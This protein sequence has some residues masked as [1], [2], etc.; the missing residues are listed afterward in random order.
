MLELFRKAISSKFGAGVAIAIL[1][2]IALSFAAGDVSGGLGFGKSGS[3][4]AVATVGGEQ[5]DASTL[6]QAATSAL[7]NVKQSDPKQTMK[8]FV[9]SG[10]L[11]NVLDG[12]IDRLAIAV[13]GKKHGIV[14]SDKLIDSEIAQMPAFKGADGKFNPAIYKQMMQQRGIS[15]GLLRNDL[16]QGLIARQIMIPASLGASIPDRLAKEYASLLTE[17]RKGEIAVLPSLAFASKDAPTDAEL[18][19]YYSEHRDRFIRP[20]RRVI[21]YAAFGEEI[22]KGDQPQPTDAEIAARYNENKAQYAAREERRLTQ[23]IVPT[24][25]AAKAVVAEIAGGKSLEVAAK[26][27]GLSTSEVGPIDKADLAKQYSQDVADAAFAAS[28][29]TMAALSHGPLGWHVIRVAGI[30]RTPEKTLAQA[31]GE[32]AKALAAEKKRA[33]LSARLEEVENAFDSGSSL[34]EEAKALGVDIK[35]TPPVTADGKVYM[36]PSESVPDT[37]KPVLQTAFSMDSEKPQLAEVEH[38]KTFVIFDVTDIAQSAPAPLKEIKDDVKAAYVLDKAAAA[39]KQAALDMQA[40]IAKGKSMKE[41]LAS[42]KRNL[43]PVQTVAMSR[44]QLAQIQ[45]QGHQVPR[46]IALLFNM[47]KGTTKVQP[48]PNEQAWFVITLSDIVPGKVDDAK[49]LEA[50]HRQLGP[51]VGSELSDALGRA[52]RKQIGVERNAAAIKAVRQKL[53]GDSTP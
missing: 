34:A 43:P 44:P 19:A 38:G 50:A 4:N 47:A 8:T 7:E 22:L 49:L 27:K 5:I 33:A 16:A 36:K 10:G 31:S 23:L 20:E 51:V 9:A 37:L 53:T 15:E 1:I 30:E 52:I 46:P 39:A 45:Q 29:G 18:G 14:A 28:Q 26:S 6:N 17:S 41:A 12:L 32:I 21:R 13:F 25:A 11:D 42:L 24:E 40:R 2:A 48:G 3:S 35:L